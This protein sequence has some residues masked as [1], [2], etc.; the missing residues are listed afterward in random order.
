MLFVIDRYSVFG[1]LIWHLA[2]RDLQCRWQN[3]VS[4]TTTPQ[5]SLELPPVPDTGYRLRNDYAVVGADLLHRVRFDDVTDLDVVV[6]GEPDAALE[7][8]L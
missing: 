1:T 7:N 6:A 3:S 4:R 8:L 2:E 5:S